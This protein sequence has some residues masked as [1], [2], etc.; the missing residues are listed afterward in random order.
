MLD[1]L[2]WV[3]PYF[4]PHYAG[5]T[6]QGSTDDGD[7]GDQAS[8]Y[9]QDTSLPQRTN[10]LR[11][12][13]ALQKS[14]T[15]DQN[16][17]SLSADPKPKKVCKSGNWLRRL[18]KSCPQ[19]QSQP[20]P[21]PS[22]SYDHPQL[23]EMPLP[24]YVRKSEAE[25]YSKIRETDQYIAF[26]EEEA[27]YFESEYLSEKIIGEGLHGMT[28]GS[29]DSSRVATQKYLSRPGYENPHVPMAIDYYI[30]ENEYILVME[31]VDE[32]WVS[33]SSYVKEKGQL[34]I[35]DARDIVREVVNGMMSLKQHGVVHGDL[36]GMSQ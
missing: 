16:D 33:L 1:P 13:E 18:S 17:A 34:D 25:S 31:Y 32:Q 29:L 24:A 21:L 7:G 20:E 35:K 19:Q 11:L 8:G 10:H 28:T 23:N 36:S 3:L 27:M 12:T 22:T 15:P 14:S 9:N 6:T 5:Q 30:L 2:L 26:T 4:T